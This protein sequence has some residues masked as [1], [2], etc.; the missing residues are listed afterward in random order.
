MKKTGIIILLFSVIFLSFFTIFLL[1]NGTYAVES[2][3]YDFTR[4]DLQNIVVSTAL[5]YFYNNE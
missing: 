4:N 2:S 5:K 3:S 1:K